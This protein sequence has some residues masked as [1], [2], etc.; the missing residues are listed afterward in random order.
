M[1]SFLTFG[2]FLF[3]S[4]H[5]VRC[6]LRVEAISFCLPKILMFIDA[7]SLDEMGTEI[8]GETFSHSLQ[9]G[10]ASVFLVIQIDL[11]REKIS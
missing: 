8:W 7:L 6:D 9:S 3:L 5:E 10:G 1:G 2:V 11:F 4:S